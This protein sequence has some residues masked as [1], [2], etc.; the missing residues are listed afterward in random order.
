MTDT[1]KKW[2][3]RTVAGRFLLREY[4]GGADG[5]GVFR[6]SSADLA[7]AILRLVAGEGAGSESQLL[8]WE[9]AK[10]LS[11]P[12]LNRVMAIGRTVEDGRE[13]FYEVEEF[14][15]ENLA[16]VIPE[17]AL[18]ADEASGMLGA[19][20]A[21]LEYLHSK[22]LV[23]GGIC[24]ANIL[25]VQDQVKLSSHSLREAGEVPSATG[26]YDAPE[27]GLHGVS[28][29]S[30]VWSLGMSLAEVMTQR[31]PSWDVGRMS[32]SLEIEGIPEPIYGIVRR[33]LEIDPRKRCEL[34]EIRERLQPGGAFEQTA[35][36]REMVAREATAME[37]KAGPRRPLWI[38]AIAVVA[39][40]IFLVSRPRSTKTSAESQA[41]N[42]A[43]SQG[44][45]RTGGGEPRSAEPLSA[46][47]KPAAGSTQPGPPEV[48][49]APSQLDRSTIPRTNSTRDSANSAT[50]GRRT[51]EQ[52][53]ARDEGAANKSNEERVPKDDIV[54]RAMPQVASSARRTIQGRIR[55]R[56]RV[57]VA[58]DGR[59]AEASFADSGPSKYFARVAEEA[60]R[61]WRFVPVEVQDQQREWTLLFVFSRGRTDVTA[62]RVRKN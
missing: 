28:T 31:Q 44:P 32:V 59:V 13:W 51:A 60:A 39:A 47:Q 7:D 15:E 34:R 57:V 46:Q 22:G 25:A 18:S 41:T 56:V 6:T 55:V 45:G 9:K 17:R 50:T 20:V 4:L 61:R 38:L 26:P 58:A 10:E 23:H 54:E 42:M 3:G 36:I 19:V 40:A 35:T 48:A 29:A 49:A 1:W 2:E 8:R 33:S 24:P 62:A 43:P 12:N 30:D 14:A 27:V 21:G 37:P 11:H 5:S 53:K 16:Q 52:E